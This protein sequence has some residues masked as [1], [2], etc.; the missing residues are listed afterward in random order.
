MEYS[1]YMKDFYK[2]YP[3]INSNIETK[4][5]VENTIKR[6][7]QKNNIEKTEG[8]RDLVDMYNYRFSKDLTKNCDL[9]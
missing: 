4:Q 2:I 6:Y 7:L 9:N 5:D 1:Q 3:K 8:I